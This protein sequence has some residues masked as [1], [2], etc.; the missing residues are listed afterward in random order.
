MSAFDPTK[1]M[2][3]TTTESMST[4]GVP[5]PVGEHVS[6]IEKVEFKQGVAK[7]DPSKSWA[8]L[9][10][11]YSIDS[12]QVKELLGRQ[13][14]TIRQNFFLD[15]N[16]Q[17]NL[18]TGKGQNVQLGRVREATGLNAAGAPFAPRMLEGKVCK[19]IVG[20]RASDRP[21]DPPG[22]VFADVNGVIKA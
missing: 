20:H 1:F 19:V 10:L 7:N 2:E 17:G 16:E 12:P 6:V 22:T 4:A 13:K 15:I 8:A 9:E 18:A 5:I 3:A 21:Q 11:T 14:V